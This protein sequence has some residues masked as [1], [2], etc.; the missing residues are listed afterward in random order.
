MIGIRAMLGRQPLRYLD[1]L[2]L[3]CYSEWADGPRK[4]RTG[5]SVKSEAA[6]ATVSGEGCSWMPLG[7][8]QA[9]S[10]EGEQPQAREPG[11]LPPA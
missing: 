10:R 11:D 6:P 8:V 5:N 3:L 4:G 7:A 9:A 2:A 1:I